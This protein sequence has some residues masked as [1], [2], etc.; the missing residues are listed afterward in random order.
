MATADEMAG[1]SEDVRDAIRV[2]EGEAV[3]TCHEAYTSRGM[4]DPQCNHDLAEYVTVIRAEL[5]RLARENAE[6]SEHQATLRFLY[7][8][9]A[10]EGDAARAELAALKRRIAEA[11]CQTC[12]TSMPITDGLVTVSWDHFVPI[13]LLGQRVALLP[14]GGEG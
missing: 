8:S 12:A 11:E 6:L 5:L 9:A 14:V 2:F 1:L 7:E 3:C 4:K 13:E 10:S